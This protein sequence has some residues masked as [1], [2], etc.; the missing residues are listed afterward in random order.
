MQLSKRSTLLRRARAKE[1]GKRVNGPKISPREASGRAPRM[2]HDTHSKWNTSQALRLDTQ[3]LKKL[4]RRSEGGQIVQELNS[5]REGKYWDDVLGGWLDPVLIPKA[6]EEEM[7]YV[8]K[9]AVYEK[10]TV[11]QCW[12]KTGKNPIKTG[13]ADTNK[14]TSECPNIR[15][16]WVAKEYNTGPRPDTCSVQRHLW[17]E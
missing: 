5:L 17:K 8:K 16:R 10:V 13:W 7:Q 11:S 12:K 6:R 9:H 1:K 2:L 4:S 3:M 14:K 15:S